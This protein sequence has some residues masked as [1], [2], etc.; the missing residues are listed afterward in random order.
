MLIDEE[1]FKKFIL[2][3]GLISKTDFEVAVKTAETKKQKIGNILLSEGKISETDLKRT[4]AFVLGI[5]FISLA[6]QKI[7]FSVLSFIPEPIARN[8]NIVAYKKSEK[9]LEVAMLDVDDL[10]IIDFIKKRSG[11]KILPRLT[12]TVSIRA[13]LAQYRKS[14][15]AEFQ[16]IIQKESSTLED[17]PSGGGE[18]TDE[19]S[20]MELKNLAED[21]PVI[22]IVDSLIFHAILQNA[23]DIHIE[24]G[25][26]ELTVRYRIDGILHDAMVLDKTAGAGI[27][28]RIKVLAN[29][30]LDEK[31]LPQDGRFKKEQDGEKIS[32][33]VSTL[34]TFFGE[35]TV[36]RI[37]KE[38]AHGFSLETLGFHGEGL[39]RIHNSLKQKTGMVLATGPTGSGKTTTLY[40]MLD[41]LNRPEVNI[42][43]VE[44]PIEYQMPR[45]NQTQVKPEIGLSFANGLRSL[46]RQD[47]DI[48]MVGEIRDGETAGLAVNASLTGHLVL[49]TIHTNSAAGAIPR[50]IDMGVEPFLITATVK[51]IIAQ[52]LV[53]KL[54]SHKEK[55]F[56]SSVEIKNLA[57]V[58]DLDR[59]LAFLKTENIVGEKDTFDK[60]PFY[61]AVKSGESEDGYLDRMGMH[62]VLKV[63]PTIKEMIISGKSQDEI[64]IQAKKEGM[65]TMLEDGVYQAILGVTTLEEVFRVVSE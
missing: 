33:R 55:Y 18:K 35:K 51:T 24:P 4:E 27:T 2:K 21:L 59:V 12:D 14:L 56:L 20:E 10:P 32:F 48:I 38:N 22:K 29:L 34:P 65:M 5:P 19:K 8:Y 62:E 45:V 23:S 52:R 42:S 63:T 3:S 57:K 17:S 7:D 25:E 26:K 41:I 36:M 43:T 61:K 54:T 50:L 40:T 47:P 37:L 16:N 39:E 1:Q 13:V 60:V 46:L 6:D 9:G 44:D 64:E 15:K 28:A 31:R 58:V 30:K 49:S 11:L 53:R